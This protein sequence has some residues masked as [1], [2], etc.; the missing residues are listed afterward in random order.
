[1]KTVFHKSIE[2]LSIAALGLS[3]FF[4]L[5]ILVFMNSLYYET[6]TRNLRDAALA[7]RSALPEGYFLESGRHLPWLEDIKHNSYRL[8]LIDTGGNVLEDSQFDRGNLDN[9]RN[10][11]EVAAALAGQEGSS[12]RKSDTAGIDNLYIALP[13]YA[14]G[15]TTGNNDTAGS[16]KATPIGVFRLALPV[17]NFRVR[18]A[19]AAL[20]YL[21]LPVLIIAA[22]IGAVYLFSRSLGKSFTR[23]VQ[24][25]QA[26]SSVPG[27]EAAPNP[28]LISDTQEFASLEKALR[29]MT[30]ELTCRIL[31]A[32][33]E[34]SRLQ[35][36][37]NGMSEA[38]FA[39]DSRLMLSLVNPRARELFDIPADRET[40]SLS[41]LE[42]THSMELETAARRVIS[43]GTA[44]E[45]E[46]SLPGTGIRHFFRV[47]AGPLG[48]TEATGDGVV[49]VLGDITRLK[50]LE[51]IRKDF[52]A[53]VSHELRTPIQV[54]KGWAETLQDSP[55]D[56]PELLLR[57]IRIIEK[58]ARAMENLTTDLLNLAALEDPESDRPELKMEYIKKLLDEAAEAVDFL[59]REKKTSI[60]VSC[61]ADIQVKVYASLII[62]A[63]INLLDNAIKYTPPGSTVIIR[64]AVVSGELT[65]EV[66]D[67]GPGIPPEHLERIFE[68]FYRIDRAHSREAGGTGLGLAIVR[69]IAL[70][71]KGL[72][73]AESRAGEGS[74]FRIRL[75]VS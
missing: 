46:L 44:L 62:Q 28:P 10:R 42:A 68:R 48:G 59:A 19:A 37:L 45:S 16:N 54:V 55:P 3:F 72:A 33:T 71:H 74:L 6:N 49:I 7:L 53:N 17:R 18:I 26:V 73:E 30:A 32:R 60:S 43:D 64:G 13:V 39:M 20:P 52:V 25:T 8:T 35:G 65:I 36:I 66:Q 12:L 9:H 31:D 40:T 24:L 15:I 11:P 4:I 27:L 75:P 70:L 61:S 38:V 50:R 51:Q 63:S 21:Y 5:A 29:D 41:L 69:H 14:P 58:N 34:G 56:D 1:M 22:A 23:L 67:N 47:F 2:V 57:G